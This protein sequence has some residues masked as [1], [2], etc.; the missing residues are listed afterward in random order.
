MSE[1]HNKF[2]YVERSQTRYQSTRRMGHE[3]VVTAMCSSEFK[4]KKN[5]RVPLSAIRLEVLQD[6]MPACAP[7]GL[8]R[9][10]FAHN[11]RRTYGTTA[12]TGLY[13]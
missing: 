10:K 5:Y 9:F 12:I 11:R 7:L 3:F 13:S 2:A 8:C 1:K 6:P 4:R